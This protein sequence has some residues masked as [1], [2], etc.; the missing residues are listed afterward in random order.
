MEQK[1]EYKGIYKVGEGVL[2]NK[3][4]ESLKAYKKLKAKNRQMDV[5]ANQITKLNNDM[6]EIKELLTKVLK[7]GIS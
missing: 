2:I 1:T 5:M 4:N 3:D 6:A 7:N